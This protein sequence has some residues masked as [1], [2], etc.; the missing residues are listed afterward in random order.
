VKSGWF[1]KKNR[2][3]MSPPE[4]PPPPDHDPEE[5]DPPGLEWE[6]EECELELLCEPL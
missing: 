4:E 5:W 2:N 3:P 1:R 6:L